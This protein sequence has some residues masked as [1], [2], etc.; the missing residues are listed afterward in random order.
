MRAVRVCVVVGVLCWLGLSTAEAA[1]FCVVGE[2]KFTVNSTRCEVGKRL[3]C[4]GENRWKEIGKC[5]EP[6]PKKG[7][8]FCQFGGK[9]YSVHSTRCEAGKQLRCVG[10]N[11]WKEIGRCKE[12]AP[13]KG[14]TPGRG[15]VCCQKG[16]K[17]Y[18]VH[19]TVCEG[20]Q[21]LRCVGENKWKVIG[22]CK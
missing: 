12:P 14:P 22:R 7:P 19:A 10:E 6:A 8:V 4:M 1:R 16:G 2:K 20:G 5:K 3:R 11:E 18:S 21:R 13:K 9:R 15:P 17:Q